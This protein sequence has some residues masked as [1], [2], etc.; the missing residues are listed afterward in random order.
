MCSTA[1]CVHANGVHLDAVCAL[2]CVVSDAEF[3]GERPVLRLWL[4]GNY[5]CVAPRHQQEL[6][7]AVE[8]DVFVRR[9]NQGPS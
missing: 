5:R 8:M 1:A 3:V 6:R 2:S 9:S 4:A 7:T